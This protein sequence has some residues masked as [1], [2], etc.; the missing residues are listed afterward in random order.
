LLL[1]DNLLQKSADTLAIGM[2]PHYEYFL[3]QMRVAQKFVLDKSLAEAADLLSIHEVEKVIGQCRAPFDTTWIECLQADRPRFATAPL[4]PGGERSLTNYRPQRVGMLMHNLGD[5][6]FSSHIFWNFVESKDTVGCSMF[7]VVGDLGDDMSW[8]EEK[9]KAFGT[10]ITVNDPTDPSPELVKRVCWWP[11]P[12]FSETMTDALDAMTDELRQKFL[13]SQLEDWAAEMPY[14]WKVL[15]LL[16]TRNVAEARSVDVAGLNKARTKQRKPLFAE[17]KILKLRLPIVQHVGP[18]SS[19]APGSMR[20]HFVRG[21]FK[22]RRTGLF[23]WSNF[24]RGDPSRPIDKTYELT[25]GKD[26]A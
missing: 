21:H 24:F 6:K 11:S 19:G 10:S 2:A 25:K 3:D 16:N 13:L 20:G 8:I 5:T 15:A 14:W 9:R 4:N 22:Q 1:C 17:H 23:W 12:F 7:M 18:S 26:H